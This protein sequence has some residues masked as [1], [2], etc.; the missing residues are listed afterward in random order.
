MTVQ[1]A[2]SVTEQKEIRGG[3]LQMLKAGHSVEK[4]REFQKNAI[5]LFCELKADSAAPA[6]VTKKAAPS[7]L[8]V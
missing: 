2:I 7:L 3:A 6:K 4:V 1:T 8:P 5:L